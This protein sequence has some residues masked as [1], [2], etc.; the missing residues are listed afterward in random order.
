MNELI[1]RLHHLVSLDEP[2]KGGPYGGYAAS[3]CIEAMREAADLLLSQAQEIER[4]SEGLRS[5][6]LRLPSADPV[7]DALNAIDEIEHSSQVAM[8]AAAS[9]QIKSDEE[10]ERMKSTIAAYEE[11]YG[12]PLVPIPD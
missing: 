8:Q 5:R 10:I 12:K 4:L 2:D 1:D 3:K 9:V 6:G 7:T 11:S